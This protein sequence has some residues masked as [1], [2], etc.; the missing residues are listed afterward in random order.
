MHPP[1]IWASIGLA[2]ITAVSFM[3]MLASSHLVS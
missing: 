3:V 2:A 1:P